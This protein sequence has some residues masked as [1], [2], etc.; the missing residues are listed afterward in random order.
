MAG[1]A[2][3]AN[4]CVHF[5]LATLGRLFVM[6]MLAQ[7]GQNAGLLALLFEALERPLKVLVLVNN[8]FGQTGPRGWSQSV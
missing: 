6:A 3:L 7:I 8:D 5:A 1:T 4:G 2:V